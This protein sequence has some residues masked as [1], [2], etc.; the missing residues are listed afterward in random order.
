LLSSTFPSPG[1][2][3]YIRETKGIFTVKPAG[4]T[5]IGHDEGPALDGI[6]DIGFEFQPTTTRA[7]TWNDE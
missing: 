2:V 5:M 1:Q 7:G 6:L 3:F 4:G